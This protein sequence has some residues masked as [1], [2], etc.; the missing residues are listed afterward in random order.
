[1]C[2]RNSYCITEFGNTTY[3]DFAETVEFAVITSADIFHKIEDDD[4]SSIE[5]FQ[6]VMEDLK[7]LCE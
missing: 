7:N 5:N 1:M 6:G 2:S 3:Y 4:K